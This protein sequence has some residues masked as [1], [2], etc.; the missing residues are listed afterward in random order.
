M[1]IWIHLRVVWYLQTMC[2]QTESA[3][4]LQ[5]LIYYIRHAKINCKVYFFSILY[6]KEYLHRFWP[7]LIYVHFGA[8]QTV[9]DTPFFSLQLF[10]KKLQIWYNFSIIKLIINLVQ[11]GLI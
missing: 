6:D 4:R 1:Q 8:R 5:K 11:F 2:V 9:A 3:M 10:K 7:S